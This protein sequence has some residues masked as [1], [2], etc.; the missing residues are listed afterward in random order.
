MGETYVYEIRVAVHFP[1]RMSAWLSGLGIY[2]EPN[3]EATL[4]G[5]L[6]DQA[7]LFGV[8]TKLHGL[9]VTLIAVQRLSS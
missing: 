8:L 5:P 1:A 7:A 9:N 3:G 2:N 6:A 4:V